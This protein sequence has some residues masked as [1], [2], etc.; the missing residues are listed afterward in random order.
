[1]KETVIFMLLPGELDLL[2][3]LMIAVPVFGIQLPV[4]E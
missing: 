4:I 3:G 2:L 1:M